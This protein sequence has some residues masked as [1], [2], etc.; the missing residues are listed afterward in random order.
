[1][2]VT[3]TTDSLLFLQVAENDRVVLKYH[4]DDCGQPCLNFI[5]IYKELSEDPK[6]KSVIFLV[7][8]AENNPMAKKHILAKRQP[9][10]TIYYKGKLLDSR[11]AGTKQGVEVLLNELLKTH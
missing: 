11:H 7:I 10:I 1:M 6:Y 2:A 5:P 8:D 3:E 9:V 4:T